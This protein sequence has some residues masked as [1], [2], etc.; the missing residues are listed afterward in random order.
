VR[1]IWHKIYRCRLIFPPQGLV[2]LE[3]EDLSLHG[4]YLTPAFF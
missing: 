4:Q 1:L 3:L 2:H